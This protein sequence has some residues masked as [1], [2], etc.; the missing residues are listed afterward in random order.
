MLLLRLSAA[1]Y[2]Y[3][4]QQHTDTHTLPTPLRPVPVHVLVCPSAVQPAYPPVGRCVQVLHA[5]RPK[6]PVGTKLVYVDKERARQR[7]EKALQVGSSWGTLW[8]LQQQLQAAAAA[9]GAVAPAGSS[10]SVCVCPTW[11]GWL[12]STSANHGHESSPRL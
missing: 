1:A 3:L 8:W 11:Q 7:E 4:K 5:E 2:S 12:R 10:P 9:R 6:H